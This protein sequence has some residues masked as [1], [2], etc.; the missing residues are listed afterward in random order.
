M[1]DLQS[2]LSSISAAARSRDGPALSKSIALPLNK[3][4]LPHMYTQLAQ[5][6]A[7]LNPL[8]Y[9]TSNIRGE[10]TLATLVGNM[11]LAL[12]AFCNER[13]QEAYDFE[14]L[15]YE[16]ALA[17]FKESETNWPTPVLLTASNDLRILASIVS[18]GSERVRE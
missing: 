11:L 3:S 8:A 17:F 15:A 12:E 14:V 2:F 6:A 16:A 10:P 9:C 5:R 1:A 18:I 4:P 7:S 13:W